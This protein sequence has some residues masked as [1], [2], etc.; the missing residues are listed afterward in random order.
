LSLRQ[1]AQAAGIS[2]E[3]ARDVRNRL[4][5][6]QSPVPDRRRK[7]RSRPEP[8]KQ[9]APAAPLQKPADAGIGRAGRAS[10]LHQLQ[11]APEFRDSESCRALLRL[12]LTHTAEAD[13]WE[14]LVEGV[15]AHQCG[16]VARLALDI[17]QIWNELA[18]LIE[19][20][21]KVA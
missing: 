11:S 8:G 16:T 13:D 17:S 7:K 18:D 10:L 9:V 5:N 14:R 20:G 2:P 6:G 12:L 1:V 21:M 19:C 3:T 15:P 4:R